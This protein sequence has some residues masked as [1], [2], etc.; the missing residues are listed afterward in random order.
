MSSCFCLRPDR[1]KAARMLPG[2]VSQVRLRLSALCLQYLQKPLYR[3]RVNNSFDATAG[4]TFS[5]GG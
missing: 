4:A 1:E 2:S 5:L 3:I